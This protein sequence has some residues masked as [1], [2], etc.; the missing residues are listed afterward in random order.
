MF[1][2]SD[3]T[4]I[5]SSKTIGGVRKTP[6]T[7]TSKTPTVG[8][9]AKYRRS[10]ILEDDEDTEDENWVEDLREYLK[11]HLEHYLQMSDLDEERRALL[12]SVVQGYRNQLGRNRFDKHTRGAA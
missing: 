11:N 10:I 2:L 12:K 3:R 8:A 1:K 5:M 4:V 6:F 9:K 7:P